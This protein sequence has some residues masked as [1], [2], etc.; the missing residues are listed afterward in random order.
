MRNLL[1][2]IILTL[3]ACR[4]VG[5]IQQPQNISAKKVTTEFKEGEVLVE[6]KGNP[7]GRV[8]KTLKTKG[9]QIH[10]VK[11][12]DAERA[13]EELRKDP[14]VAKVSLNYKREKQ[15]FDD[16]YLTDGTLWGLNK[17]NAPA[18]WASG[19]IGKNEVIV[20]TMDEGA[21]YWH[22]DLCNALWINPFDQEDNIDND[23]NGFI[24]DIRGWNA[25]QDNNMIHGGASFNHGTHV[26]G[27]IA[28][29]G[30]NGQGVVG[31]APK[32]KIIQG[33]F[34]EQNG[35]DTDAIELFYYIVDLKQRHNLNIVAVNCSWGGG[36]YSQFLKEAID[37]A[38][39]ANIMVVCAAGNSAADMETGEFYPASYDCANIISVG[40]MDGNNNPAYF[41]NY[42]V[43]KVDLFA[44]GV[45]IMSTVYDDNILPAYKAY[46]G[47]SMAAPHVTGAVALWFSLNPTGTIQQAKQ[48][49]LSNTISAGAL[50]GKCVT[51]GYLNVSSFT[52]NSG[53][54]NQP[55]NNTCTAPAIDRE[56]PTAP[57][58]R[59][60]GCLYGKYQKDKMNLTHGS[61][62]KAGHLLMYPVYR[63]V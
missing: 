53:G 6:F 10:V 32:V 60:T 49:I 59:N 9:R 11:V 40:A 54:A 58:L 62:L 7:S 19:N 12:D 33:K 45:N 46:N 25:L 51:G 26:D 21:M 18:A 41:S 36:G 23:G 30:N 38:G 37:A 31:V 20:M 56:P 35:Y 55:D 39:A 43:T 13:V 14:N 47:T 5:D 44:P 1:L 63:V 48:A 42:G 24:D 34:L 22:P 52:G 2:L 61:F 16:P 4:K 27:T 28:G 50:A 17:I 8:T 29:T 3:F 15:Q 57:T